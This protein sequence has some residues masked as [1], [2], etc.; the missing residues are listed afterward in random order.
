MVHL[1]AREEMQGNSNADHQNEPHQMSVYTSGDRA[2][3]IQLHAPNVHLVSNG[4][5]RRR[6]KFML[7]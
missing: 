6:I 5:F 7:T 1:F 3:I 2:E 4:S